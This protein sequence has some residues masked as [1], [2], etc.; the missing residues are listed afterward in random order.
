MEFVDECPLRRHCFV[1][2]E[3]V[4][5][6]LVLVGINELRFL[7]TERTSEGVIRIDLSHGRPQET[8]D[9]KDALLRGHR[10]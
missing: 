4:Q 5:S 7:P 10:G 9:L 8:V 6:S 3:N 2:P 1:S